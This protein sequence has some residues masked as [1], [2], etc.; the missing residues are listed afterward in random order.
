M[1]RVQTSIILKWVTK[2]T[3][4]ELL[5]SKIIFR[6]EKSLKFLDTKMNWIQ[7]SF[8]PKWQS[9]NFLYSKMTELQ[10]SLFQ[11]DRVKTFFIPKWQSSNFLY[12]KMTEFQLS[13]FQNEQNLLFL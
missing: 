1:I 5:N 13:L 12:S 9:S 7:T 6:N 8:I 10:L 4:F 2:W 11:N 3:Q